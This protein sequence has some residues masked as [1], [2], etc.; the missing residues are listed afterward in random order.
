MPDQESVL[1]WL[2]DVYHEVYCSED[3]CSARCV[4]LCIRRIEGARVKEAAAPHT[5]PHVRMKDKLV[6]WDFYFY[7]YFFLFELKHGT[8]VL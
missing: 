2:A 3:R 8:N 5:P 7:F 1:P 4:S 6:G